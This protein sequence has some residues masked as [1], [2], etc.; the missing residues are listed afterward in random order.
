MDI[1]CDSC[2]AAHHIDPPA[3]VV[4][5]GRAFRFRCSACGH[6]QMV[7]PTTATGN[8]IRP[9]E[10]A[11]PAPA[12]SSATE[13]KDDAAPV[14][15]KQ[16][17]KV[18]LVRDWATLQR[19][20]MERRVGREDLVSEGGVRWEPVG[21]RADLGTF[22][23][24]IEQPAEA[25]D[26][27]VGPGTRALPFEDGAD[28]N[29]GPDAWS[30][31]GDDLTDGVPLGLPPLPTDERPTT[32]PRWMDALATPAPAPLAAPKPAAPVAPPAAPIAA[33]A[34]PEPAPD[35]AP[36]AL[37]TPP[38]TPVRESNAV[39]LAYAS[40]TPTGAPTSP[41]PLSSPTYYDLE[42][43]DFEEAPAQSGA[44]NPPPEMEPLSFG[45]YEDLE[46]PP[47][48]R[49][50]G[51]E[52]PSPAIPR[53]PTASP[54]DV[55]EPVAP[56][57]ATVSLPPEAPTEP[58]APARAISLPPGTAG[59]DGFDE[60]FTDDDWPVVVKPSPLPYVLGAAALVL[61]LG[62]GGWWWTTRTGPVAPPPTPAATAPAATAPKPVPAPAAPAPVPAPAP[63]AE[64]PPMDPAAPVPTPATAA[65]PPPA[66]TPA[67]PTAPAP[68][69]K[70]A[71][72]AAPAPAP[73]PPPKPTPPAAPPAAP[74]V[75]KPAPAPAPAAAPPPAPAGDAKALIDKGWAAIDSGKVSDAERLFKSALAASP[76]SAA[77]AYGYGYA[78]IESGRADEA[79]QY[80][81]RALSNNPTTEDRREIE[82]VLR[83]KSLTCP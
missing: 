13:P 83:S 77:A 71:A 72:P 5:S 45:G 28:T 14:Y 41:A 34:R 64:P 22:F 75:A 1:V 76:S 82:G 31:G 8:P 44:F 53:A 60:H 52:E 68:A 39:D 25:E 66:P 16:D 57:R 24:A 6:S 17:G 26:P 48:P 21:S 27:R 29:S 15:L 18:Y 70:A 50:M 47:V 42:P 9:R 35:V 7:Q 61:L 51:I 74:A 58:H 3:W 67:A 37:I 2:G 33:P 4:A 80:L 46:L 56:P 19:W 11:P 62:V 79:A 12:P 54:S 36:P 69:P 55:T 43:I 40:A 23:A 32:P 38:A 73:A 20:I 81:C 65:A 49:G 59:G 63:A 78:L 30:P 10:A